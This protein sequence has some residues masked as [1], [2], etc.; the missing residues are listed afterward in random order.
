VEQELKD[1]GKNKKFVLFLA[2]NIEN[3]L[4]KVITTV[5]I[6]Y[7]A[8]RIDRKIQNNLKA[9]F[10]KINCYLSSLCNR[11]SFLK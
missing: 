9:T 4:G 5:C 8:F 2:I 7:L 1:L 10:L 11:N 3:F 6:L